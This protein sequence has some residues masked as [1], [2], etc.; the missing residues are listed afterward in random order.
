MSMSLVLAQ[1]G[2]Q[3]RQLPMD[4]IMYGVLALAAFGLL[5]AVTWSFRST[6]SK[7]RATGQRGGHGRS[8]S[9]DT[10]GPGHH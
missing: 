1:G 10:H 2:E 4:P 3:V 8:G 9:D 5:L 6:A 7:V